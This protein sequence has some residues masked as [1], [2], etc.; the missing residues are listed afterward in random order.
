M[1]LL[2]VEQNS[3]FDRLTQ[4][5]FSC[6]LDRDEELKERL[7]ES[8]KK[9]MYRSARY[10]IEY[11]YTALTLQDEAIF[12]QYARWLYQLLCSV[13]SY[14]TRERMKD[15]TIEH[16]ELIRAC[17]IKIISPDQHAQLH[18]FLDRAIQITVEEYENETPIIYEEGTYEKE[19]KKYLDYLLRG[20]AEGAIDLMAQYAK[21]G[22]SLNDIYAEIA[23]ETMRRVGDLWHKR[24]ITVDTEHFCTSTTQTA[25]AQFY[26]LIFGQSRKGYTVLVACIGSELHEL[27]ARTVA[28]LFEYNGWDSVYL[29]AAV[30]PEVLEAAV[31]EHQPNLVAL[32]VTL[33]QHLILCR[34]E[35]IR[36]RTLYP[37]VKIAVGGNAFAG[38]DVWKAW[39]IDIYTKDDR[40]SI[41]LKC[42][43]EMPLPV[44]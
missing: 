43:N 41:P 6:Q 42:W 26:P 29:G 19:I 11:L 18:H 34:D 44:Y 37:K 40:Q 30:S 22:I 15:I 8:A 12:C 38:T 31:E 23:T 32:S 14:Y 13:M 33:P 28:D 25:L 4:E 21:D 39:D 36:L 7:N 35:I 24:A 1:S 27:G 9:S 16:Y 10:N 2:V 5:V 17:M 3:E 20:D